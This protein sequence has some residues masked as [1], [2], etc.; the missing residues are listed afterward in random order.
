MWVF[1]MEPASYNLAGPKYFYV[2]SKFLNISTPLAL[3]IVSWHGN[4]L[5]LCPGNELEKIWK[6]GF[7][8]N[9]L[10]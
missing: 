2:V 7:V 6:A 10:P 9:N 4:C 5:R 1:R 3:Q 8:T